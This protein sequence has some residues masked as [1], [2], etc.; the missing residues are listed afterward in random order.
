MKLCKRIYETPEPNFQG[1]DTSKQTG[2]LDHV[3]N[4]LMWNAFETFFTNYDK[5]YG[6]LRTKLI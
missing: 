5:Q 6:A 4:G 1:C 3:E 2:L